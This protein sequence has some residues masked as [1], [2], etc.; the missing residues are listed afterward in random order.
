MQVKPPFL[1]G[2]G[3][4]HGCNGT[5]EVVPLGND[6]FTD[7]KDKFPNTWGALTHFESDFKI[8]FD[9]GIIIH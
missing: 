1:F 4:S 3:A 7:L 8:K 2:A 6:L 9:S 5:N